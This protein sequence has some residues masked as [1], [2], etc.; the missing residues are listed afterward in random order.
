MV[1]NDKVI[2]SFIG[3]HLFVLIMLKNIQK[4]EGFKADLCNAGGHRQSIGV[5]I[6]APSS[7]LDWRDN[8]EII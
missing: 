3:C 1:A 7:A 4:L 6:L 8:N 5:R 2:T